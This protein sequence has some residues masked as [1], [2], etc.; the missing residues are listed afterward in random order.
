[1]NLL[2]NTISVKNSVG[3]LRGGGGCLIYAVTLPR[4]SGQDLTT[5]P[6]L[7]AHNDSSESAVIGV[8]S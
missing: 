6:I 7:I 2:T 4:C 5:R 8:K 3:C 1:M